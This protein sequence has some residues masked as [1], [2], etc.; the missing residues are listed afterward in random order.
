MPKNIVHLSD[1]HLAIIEQDIGSRL[2]KTR[3]MFEKRP[4]RRDLERKVHSYESLLLAAHGMPPPP[5]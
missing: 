2:E 4:D 5:R 1:R 3:K